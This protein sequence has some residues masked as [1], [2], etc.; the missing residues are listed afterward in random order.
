M[1]R[2]VLLFLAILVGIPSITNAD[3]L[4]PAVV[5]RVLGF[6][7]AARQQ[8]LGPTAA[9]AAF[10]KD[11]LTAFGRPPTLSL[12]ASDDLDV[13]LVLPLAVVWAHVGDQLRKLETIAA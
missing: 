1:A 7:A 12:V 6:A 2:A 10:N 8:G 13:S 5:H 4:D 3:G 9:V 11:M